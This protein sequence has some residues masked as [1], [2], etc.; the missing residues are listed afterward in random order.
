MILMSLILAEA[1]A[2]DQV[3]EEVHRLIDLGL[4]VREQP[5]IRGY[6]TGEI[7]IE[8]KTLTPMCLRQA[9]GL[10]VHEVVL[11]LATAGGQELQS[12]EA[13]TTLIP[14]GPGPLHDDSHQD[15]MTVHE[16]PREDALDHLMAVDLSVH[17]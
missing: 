5:G 12:T 14:P 13:E 16:A 15:E 17:P 9:D 11:P 10:N 4:R 1:K 6:Q 3:A 2:T 8:E 7:R